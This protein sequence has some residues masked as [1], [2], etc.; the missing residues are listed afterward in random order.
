MKPIQKSFSTRL[1]LNILLATSLLFIVAIGIASISSHMLI[2]KEAELSASHLLDATINEIELSMREIETE[3]K[4]T[5]WMVDE[6]KND[7]QAM[8]ALTAEAIKRNSKIEGCAIAFSANYYDGHYYFSPYS[9]RDSSTGEIKT[10]QLG[11]E[12]WDYFYM[13]WYQIPAL[14]GKD[15]WCEPYFDEGGG[16]FYMST[17]SYPLKDK[18]GKLIAII[19]A[20]VSIRWITEL[21]ETIKPYETSKV[22]LISRSGSYIN[23]ESDS[24]LFGET[25]YSKLHYIE[26]SDNDIHTL[27]S[28]MMSGEKG[29]DKFSRK[30]QMSFSVFGPLANGW[31]LSILCDY[32][33]VLANT[34]KMQSIL[35]IVGIIG[36]LLIF[37][38]CYGIV[39]K[40][41][42]PLAALSSSALRIAKGDFD[43]TLPEIESDDEIQQLKNSF[44]Y[45][46]RSL[47]EYIASLKKS[48]AT[49]ERFE[50]ELSVA[51]KIQMS[52]L[53]KVFPQHDK[54]DL[55][56]LL[57]PAKEVGGDY[58]D[59]FLKGNLLYF[60]IGDAAGKGI[61]AAIVMA[62]T[63]SIFH[64][65]AG[66]G[67]SPEDMVKK[68]NNSISEG[69]DNG[70]FVTMF[71]GCLNLD[72]MELTYCNAGHNPI[73]IN[74]NFLDE[75]PNIACGLIPDFD[76]KI[77]SIQLQKNSQLIIYTD[78]VNEAECQDGKQFGNDRLV[79]WTKQTGALNSQQDI[80]MNLL[81]AI[82]TFTQENEQNDDI[83]IMAIKIK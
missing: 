14:S 74:G 35:I 33:S 17:Y 21:L 22:Y 30:N 57:K 64:F 62:I 4:G 19:T 39:K 16:K 37:A 36:L 54:F 75:K 66:M 31:I 43:T 23:T 10:K 59:F 61:P 8:Y 38:L 50:N 28:K 58:Y 32:K 41:T 69:N 71:V 55:Y 29:M 42:S 18:N 81:Y 70:M 20:D 2:S 7:P 67:L 47:K 27:V 11:N 3:V 15:G 77:Q 5:A 49:N 80:C 13:D 45:M 72:T 9:Y 40:N 1:S 44:D 82:Q 68:I 65:V 6:K 79:E 51:S 12:S 53:Q 76:Y 25:I 34:S 24:S 56:A 48:T 52:M 60:T 83:T 78:G 63:K 73:I 46:Q 26:D